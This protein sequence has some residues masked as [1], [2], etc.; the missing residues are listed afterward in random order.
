MS[1]PIRSFAWADRGR[2]VCRPEV[3]TPQ[4]Y[5]SASRTGIEGLTV[6]MLC[7]VLSLR[8]FGNASEL[9]SSHLV[10][11]ANQPQCHEY[12]FGPVVSK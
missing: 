12:P 3:Q 1:Y 2:V 9:Q 6:T 10:S 5:C 8:A 7:A 11:P 4:R